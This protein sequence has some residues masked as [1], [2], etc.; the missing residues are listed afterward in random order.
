M[1]KQKH[2]TMQTGTNGVV[3]FKRLTYHSFSLGMP[4]FPC[5]FITTRVY[6]YKYIISS[7]FFVYN[8]Y[9]CYG[10]SPHI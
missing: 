4:R 10:L 9:I 1:C 3:V 5:F 6:N 8:S 2:V 7:Q